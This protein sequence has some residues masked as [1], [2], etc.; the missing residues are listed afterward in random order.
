MDVPISGGDQDGAYGEGEQPC[1]SATESV[2]HLTPNSRPACGVNGYNAGVSDRSWV[3]PGR[4]RSAKAATRGG[5]P[6]P[7]WAEDGAGNG[8]VTMK[9]A[10][11]RG[12]RYPTCAD[13]GNSPAGAGSI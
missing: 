9:Q 3:R 6:A 13:A 10:G 1:L 12:G 2:I 8:T 11:N 5:R 4:F 7:A